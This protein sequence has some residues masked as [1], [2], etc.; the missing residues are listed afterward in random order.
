MRTRLES[1]SL[2]ESS[3][4]DDMK[5]LVKEGVKNNQEKDISGYK[6]QLQEWNEQRTVSL[7]TAL[8]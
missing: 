6:K 7:F 5:N 3:L 8:Y 4:V 2:L 1:C